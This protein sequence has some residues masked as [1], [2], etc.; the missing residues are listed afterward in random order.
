LLIDLQKRVTEMEKADSWRNWLKSKGN[1]VA[2]SSFLAVVCAAL[3][4][5]AWIEPRF[6]SHA[7]E[8]LKHD[9]GDVVKEQI[10]PLLERQQKTSDQVSG[11]AS[12]IGGLK[13]NVKLLLENALK[14]TASLSQQQF[15]EN[16]IGVSTQLALSR[17]M[18]AVADPG[19]IKDIREK[20]IHS[21]QGAGQPYWMAAGNFITYTS[22]RSVR[23]IEDSAIARMY[24]CLN[25]PP[26]KTGTITN[27]TLN[28][29]F[30]CFFALDGERWTDV[31]VANAIIIYRG[32]TV[33]L[34]NV[35]FDNCYF[36]MDVRTIPPANG[37]QVIG[38]VLAAMSSKIS[39]TT[40]G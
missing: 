26:K 22:F 16:L 33:S 11:L 24:P 21:D 31:K 17:G 35:H 36:L 8:D 28:A 5:F 1:K 13:D 32:G 27:L 38:E 30:N 12:D 3:T 23:S 18:N 40:P 39:L 37:K 29:Q 19:V 7:K 20:L 6:S 15:D 34:I 14:T 10:Q 25:N 4:W 2:V 9:I